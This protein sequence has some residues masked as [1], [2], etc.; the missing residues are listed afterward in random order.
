M[1][2]L[3][4]MLFGLVL[5]GALAAPAVAWPE[6]SFIPLFEGNDLTGWRSGK[7]ILHRV[8]ESPE[9]RFA[10]SGSILTI[11]S[12]DK[13]G[14][15]DAREI[16]TVRELARD[17]VLKL[18][19]KASQEATASVS[20]RGTSIPIADFIRRNEQRQLK[21]FR[22]DGWNEREI[23]VKMAAHAEGKRLKDT[24]TL[25]ASF[26]NGKAVAKV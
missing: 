6:P 10:V 19:F 20:V 15:K 9:G 25:E 24:D 1:L 4:R 18:E 13:D 2:R 22:T 5:A 16:Y 7:T 23:T 11:N 3:H 21:S 17:F 12:R 26:Q 14:K 8:T